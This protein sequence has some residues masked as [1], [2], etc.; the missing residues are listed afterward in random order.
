MDPLAEISKTQ[1]KR[2]MHALQ[3]LGEELVALSAGRLA[4]IALPERLRD[5]IVEARRMSK[6][7][8]R[9]RQLQYIGRLMREVDAGAIRAQLGAWKDAAA[10]DTAVLHRAEYWRDRLLQE[11]CAL[12]ELLERHPDADAQRVHTLVRNARQEATLLKPP[13]SARALFR[14]L[15][16]LFSKAD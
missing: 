6:W 4:R 11:T 14:L 5:A 16:E 12:A 3:A 1:R 10:R 15:H 8:A 7:G 13:K 9:R 2:E